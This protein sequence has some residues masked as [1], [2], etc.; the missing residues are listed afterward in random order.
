MTRT[1]VMFFTDQL[2]GP[3]LVDYALRCEGLGIDTVWLPEV[4]GRE[5]FSSAGFV[6]ARTTSVRIASGIANV[7]ARDAMSTRQAA[8]TLAELS[9]GRFVLGLGVSNPGIVA[10]RGGSWEPP[11][12]KLRAYFDG[13]DA[14]KVYAPAPAEPAPVYLAAHGPGLLKLAAERTD[15]AN[16]YLMPTEHTVRARKQLGATPELNVVQHC[17]YLPS[18]DAEKARGLARRAVQRYVELDYY[19]RMWSEFGFA[20]NDFENGGSDALIDMLVAWGDIETIQE[21][22]GAHRAAGA[23]EVVVVPLNPEGGGRAP[24]WSLLEGLAGT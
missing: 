5:V 2:T 23:N 20:D 18:G 3:D 16:T 22:L 12:R 14:A 6:L 15:G 11:V 17:L 1:G 19:R 13:M 9:G 8:Q 24:H 10:G 4:F 7:Y 21:R